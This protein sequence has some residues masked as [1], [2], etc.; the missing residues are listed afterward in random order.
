MDFLVKRIRRR[1]QEII[2][3]SESKTEAELAISGDSY[4]SNEAIEDSIRRAFLLTI[5]YVDSIHL[6]GP[7]QSIASIAPPS[8]TLRVLGSTMTG[9]NDTLHRLTFSDL[10]KGKVG[11]VL[12][13]AYYYDHGDFQAGPGGFSY[14]ILKMPSG[15]NS[16]ITS[17]SEVILSV[18]EDLSV[19]ELM[20]S[21]QMVE[22]FDVALKDLRSRIEGL[23]ITRFGATQ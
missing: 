4:F 1:L 5:C 12:D 19:I 15:V 22:T 13:P 23:A 18:V 3:E 11:T 6:A 8:T 17:Q 7:Y 10:S 16:E 2:H 20:L 9:V 21:K 14:D